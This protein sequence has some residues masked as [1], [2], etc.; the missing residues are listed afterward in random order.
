MAERRRSKAEMIRLRIAI[1]TLALE[2]KSRK[3]IALTV[4]ASFA[5]V[6]KILGPSREYRK[7]A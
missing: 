6:T 3:A 1:H 5:Q 4:G 2:G 7:A